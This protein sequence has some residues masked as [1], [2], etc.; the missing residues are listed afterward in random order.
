[1]TNN[2]DDI[3]SDDLFDDLT[4]QVKK[5]KAEKLDPEII[6]FQEI[7]N[8]VK[9][10]DREPNKTDEW[11]EERALW[12]RLQGFREKK[13]RLDKVKHLDELNLLDKKG[14]F[15]D[16]MNLDNNANQVNNLN[17]VSYTHLTLPTNREV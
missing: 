9:E 7:L 2:L 17:A 13:E 14:N 5:K 11:S 6:K 1:M 3:F 8:F 10:N 16:R 15:S 4:K 12:A